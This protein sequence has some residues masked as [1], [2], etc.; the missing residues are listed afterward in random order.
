MQFHGIDTREVAESWRGVI[1]RAEPI[2]DADV[3]WVHEMIGCRVLDAYGTDR[4][5]VTAVQDNPASDLLVLDTGALVPLTFVVG[6][7]E[8]GVIR[9]EV[10]D[11]LFELFEG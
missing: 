1:L 11:G 4:G 8:E 5:L 10:P 3:L 7:P 2:E 9:V 6:E